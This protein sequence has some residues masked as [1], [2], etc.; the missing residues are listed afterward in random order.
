MNFERLSHPFSPRDEPDAPV[1]APLEI[2]NA[3]RIEGVR[4]Q[5]LETSRN[6]MLVT[7]ALLSLAFLVIA[8]RLVDLTALREAGEPA[9]VARAADRPKERADIVDRNGILLATSLP[10]ASLYANPRHVLDPE[11]AADRLLTALPELNRDTVARRLATDG[12]FVWLHR[13]LTPEMQFKVNALGQPGLYFQKTER[14]VYP[15]GTLAS[16]VMG[17]TDIDGGGLSGLE[18]YFNDNLAG[19]ASI[20]KSSLDIR[21]QSAMRDELMRA[22]HEFQAIGASGIIMDVHTGEVLAMVSLPD[23]DP[24]H[25]ATASGEAAFN[26]A[27]KGVYE[28]GSTMKLFT[29]AMSLD[30]GMTDLERRYDATT[31]IKIGRFTIRD[32]HAKNRWLT[33]P[34]IM[35]HSSNIGAAKMALEVG[36]AMQ[37][38]YLGDF[39]FLK[40]VHFEL[41]EIGSPL[42]PARWREINTITVAYGHGIAISPLQVVAA[43]AAMVNGGILPTPTLIKRDDDVRR[44]VGARVISRG[45]SKH[46]RA[47][48]RMVVE[49]G[50]GRNADLPGYLIGG[51]TGTADKAAGRGYNTRKLISSFVGV[52]PIDEPEYAVLAIIDEPKGTKKTYGYATGGWVAAPVVKNVV[53]QMAQIMGLT[54]ADRMAL[55]ESEQ[56]RQKKPGGAKPGTPKP[57]VTAQRTEVRAQRLPGG[58]SVAAN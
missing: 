20:L 11:Q 50:T 3:I 45:T 37:K 36:T 28:M 2:P 53:A 48:M 4:A 58:Q 55:E 44:T 22:M 40:P 43:T 46:M 34:E 29:A 24:N 19:R 1:E 54:P 12:S 57:I 38:K 10:T 31:P 21:V 32:Y 52:F 6:R 47:L 41:P 18:K 16:H 17:L 26:R 49:D 51:K 56:K 13:N 15:Q 25:P 7:G 42:S 8:V 9:R 35:I 23:F 5:A 27:T 14:R 39:G 33:V 30:M